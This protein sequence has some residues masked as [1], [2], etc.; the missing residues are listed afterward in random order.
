MQNS[1]HERIEKAL[2]NQCNTPIKA[3]P[4]SKAKNKML[5]ITTN[6]DLDA[7]VYKDL[8][9]ALL[10]MVNNNMLLLDNKFKYEVVEVGEWNN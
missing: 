6:S 1:L 2:E 8:Y 5:I 3:V 9:N 7:D 10:S 4:L